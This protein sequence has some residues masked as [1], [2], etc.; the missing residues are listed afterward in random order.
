MCPHATI[1]VLILLYMCPYTTIY[2]SSYFY[3]CVLILVNMWFHP[4]PPTRQHQHQ[5]PQDDPH[6]HQHF[7]IPL[8]S[9][10]NFPLFFLI[11]FKHRS[12]SI[13]SSTTCLIRTRLIWGTSLT[14]TRSNSAT[15]APGSRAGWPTPSTG[16]DMLY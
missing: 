11:V 9:T 15:R 3:I 16:A 14:R 12:G 13:R 8:S 4:K 1:C 7:N 10:F 6:A 2:A 5:P